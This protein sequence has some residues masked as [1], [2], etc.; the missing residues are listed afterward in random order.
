MNIVFFANGQFAIP[1][2]KSL[3]NSKHNLLTVISN[4]DKV[5]GR[6]NKKISTPVS[7]Y[8]KKLNI[9]LYKIDNINNEAFAQKLIK[10]NADI[11]I[12]ISYKIIPEK[13]FSIPS[14][15][16]INVHASLLP[17]YKGAAPIQRSIINNENIIGLTVFEINSKIDSGR[18]I[19]QKKYCLNNK[20]NYGVIHDMLSIESASLLQNSLDMIRDKKCFSYN[21]K[22]NKYAN[23][24][25]KEEFKIELNND[26]ILINNMFRA[27]TPPGPYLFF[28]SKKIK[29]FNTSCNMKT[30]MKAGQWKIDNR[31]LYI[32]CNK[33]TLIAENV[34]FEGKKIITISDFKNMNHNNSNE[35]E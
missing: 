23:K 30:I 15:N 26:A 4:N 5:G 10:L 19:N 29:L 33:G 17:S 8:C 27:L 25:Q 18:I 7:K 28:K 6:G 13:I 21:I 1:S 12:T 35:F 14:Y 32:G 31:K 22:E 3:H 9:N 16:T 34:Q 11:F 20:D 2:I 24:I